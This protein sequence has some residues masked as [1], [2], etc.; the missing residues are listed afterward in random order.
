MIDEKKFLSDL[1]SDNADTRF[2]AWRAAGEASPNVIPELGK[3]ASSSKPGVAKAGREALTTM[4]HAVGKDAN[5][6]NRAG[7]V[8]GLLA[9]T[10]DG[11]ALPVRV[12]AVRLLS[13]IGGGDAVPGIAKLL[14]NAQLREEAIYA[15]EQIPGDASIDA[16]VAA[17]KTAPDDFKPRLLAALGHRR[18]AKGVPLCVEAFKSP[19]ADI[20]VAAIKAAGR[21]G[22]EISPT[23][24][25]P[26][27]AKLTPFQRAEVMDA[28]L[29]Y[30][31]AMAASGN[32]TEA[33]RLYRM[34][35]NSPAPHLQCAGVIGLAKIGTAEAAS[36]IL[37]LTKSGNKQVK[38]V[39]QSA[40]KS[41]AAGK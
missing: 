13:N 16:I 39:A 36:A 31:D 25:M 22:V 3:I 7:V 27:M 34:A 28:M 6:P 35:V 10:G 11:N 14:S 15:L 17:Y 9:L 26:D 37:P 33:M 19:N 5:A 2:P 8:K 4:T 40:W 20:V 32:A 24:Q 23:P 18:A 29:R 38:I 21:I 30:A 41:M 1:Q 12:H